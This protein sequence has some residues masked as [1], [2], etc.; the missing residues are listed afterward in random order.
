[1]VDLQSTRTLA[2]LTVANGTLLNDEAQTSHSVTVPA[3]STD[4]SF[5]VRTYTIQLN[6]VDEFD[7]SVITDTNSAADAVSERGHGNAGW[8]HRI[9]PRQ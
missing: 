9:S 8:D 2:I 3:T 1:M 7:V 5:S 6:D 4:G